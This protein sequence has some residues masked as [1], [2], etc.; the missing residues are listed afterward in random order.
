MQTECVRLPPIW[1]VELIQTAADSL[2]S[3]GVS[4]ERQHGDV[5]LSV[6]ETPI[7]LWEI[8]REIKEP[9]LQW[10][11]LEN[12]NKNIFQTNFEVCKVSS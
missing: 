2:Q 1:T 4:V 3:A 10:V 5:G 11:L 12:I 6:G 8:P 7:S 9:L